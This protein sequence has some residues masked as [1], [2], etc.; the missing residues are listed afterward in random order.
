M[1]RP[2]RKSCGRLARLPRTVCRSTCRLPVET[3]W[4][5][6]RLIRAFCQSTMG[7]G[8]RPAEANQAVPG[9]LPK[10]RPWIST[11][12][13]PGWSSGMLV[14]CGVSDPIPALTPQYSRASKAATART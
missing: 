7:S 5:R 1:V 14:I 10:L 3:P 11:V 8:W 12:V 2:V 6:R 4:G 13:A 9:W